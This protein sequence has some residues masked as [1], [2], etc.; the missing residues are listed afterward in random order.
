MGPALSDAPLLLADRRAHGRRHPAGDGASATAATSPARS[1]S[2]A[3]TRSTAATGAA[4]RTTPSCIS[5]SATTRPSISR[6][7]RGLKRVEAGA[8][9]EHKLAR[10][11][12]PVTTHSAHYI[13]HPGPAPR[14]RRLS[15]AG[16]PGRRRGRR[17]ADRTRPLPQDR[18]APARRRL[19]DSGR[20][21]E[22]RGERHDRLRPRQHL[23]QDPARRDPL[24]QG[25]RGRRRLRL[26]GRDAAGDRPH[27]GRS[28]GAVAQ[29]ARCRSCDAL[30]G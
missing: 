13:A 15:R 1:T 24:A 22:H 9:G 6:S 2:S 12:V 4:S 19:T 30:A 23:R 28:Q 21:P 11:Y 16:A 29:P 17:V 26:H 3:R 27:A 18:R 10:G 8:Q 14:R 25:L 20:R 7:H 5:R